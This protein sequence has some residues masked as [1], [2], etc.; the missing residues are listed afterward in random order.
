MFLSALVF[1]GSIACC[2]D[3]VSLI[4]EVPCCRGSLGQVC[5]QGGGLHRF[6]GQ[7]WDYHRP[8]ARAARAGR[9]TQ[10]RGQA[11]QASEDS[12]TQ[13]SDSCRAAFCPVFQ[14]F[15]QPC[16]LPSS[17]CLAGFACECNNNN[18][19]D[20]G[21]MPA[22]PHFAFPGSVPCWGAVFLLQQAGGCWDVGLGAGSSLGVMQ[23]Q[24]GGGCAL[25]AASGVLSSN[26]P[27]SH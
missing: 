19:R 10:P 22:T 18:S 26:G 24:G 17:V 8:G 7:P 12:V 14:G 4:Y 25:F 5:G 9:P 23:R 6:P 11:W 13:C 1:I 21:G 20:A 16:S 27:L 15:E 2:N 3:I